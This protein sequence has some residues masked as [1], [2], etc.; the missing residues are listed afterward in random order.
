MEARSERCQRRLHRDNGSIPSAHGTILMMARAS[1]NPSHR[2]FANTR[3][4]RGDLGIPCF[5]MELTR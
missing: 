4:P 1:K 3:A 5:G 2:P